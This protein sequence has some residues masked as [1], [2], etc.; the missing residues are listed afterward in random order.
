MIYSRGQR[1]RSQVILSVAV[2]AA[3]GTA[4]VFLFRSERY[5]DSN[6]QG[7]SFGWDFYTNAPPST[8]RKG[9]AERGTARPS[10]KPA[11]SDGPPR[12]S[13][14]H[15]DDADTDNAD[16]DNDNDPGTDT[17]TDTDSGDSKQQL[18]PLVITEVH[19]DSSKAS[20][21]RKRSGSSPSS[22]F[23]SQP[24]SLEVID[25]QF[26]VESSPSFDEISQ[27]EH[28]LAIIIPFRDLEAKKDTQSQ[29]RTQN[30]A[31]FV[32]HMNKFLKDAPFPWRI[33]VAEQNPDDGLWF[34]KGGLFNAGFLLSQHP[35]FSGGLLRVD[36]MVFNDVDQVPENAANDHR[37]P[38]SYL[39]KFGGP[40]ASAGADD[41][42]IHLCSATSQFKYR[43]AY[44]TMVGGALMLT[45]G[46]YRKCNGY[47]THYFG[48][49]L[50][51]D[52]M[53][54]RIQKAL[55]GGVVRPTGDAGRYQA[56]PHPRVMGL[57]ETDVFVGNQ[58]YYK[59][60]LSGQKS[61]YD[62][63]LKQTLFRVLDWT[64]DDEAHVDRFVVDF[65]RSMVNAK[66]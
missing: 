22:T 33:I 57:D 5:H 9:D 1:T 59:Q 54:A 21:G 46:A 34:N 35:D 52:D 25:G 8:D 14:P 43:I 61:I 53:Y 17:D 28:G 13:T 29:G 49:G 15:V 64:R 20:R 51:D 36:Y 12:R 45:K 31:D 18:R 60:I 47:S 7:L 40:K 32:K 62:S 11:A 19:E 26:S 44:E 50:E 24:V 48:W 2:V 4:M 39:A 41:V 66:D 37:H 56:L 3:I 55:R 27:P 16:T 23:P 38:S 10:K 63:G 6:R 65:D 42:A 30:L 58:K